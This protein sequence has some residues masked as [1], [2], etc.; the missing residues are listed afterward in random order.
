MA[1]FL[2][3]AS[4]Q[5]IASHLVAHDTVRYS[6]HTVQSGQQHDDPVSCTTHPRPKT[7]RASQSGRRD[8]QAG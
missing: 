3:S 5:P 1:P 8:Q 6:L 4:P 7:L 2:P